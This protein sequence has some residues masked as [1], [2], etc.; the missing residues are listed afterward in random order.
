MIHRRERP[1]VP[2]LS[3]SSSLSPE[4][5][6]SRYRRTR[7][8]LRSGH[9]DAEAKYGELYSFAHAPR[10]IIFKHAASS[11]S[12]VFDMR[13]GRAQPPRSASGSK[14]SRTEVRSGGLPFGVCH[15]GGG[16][17]EDP[18][19]WATTFIGEERHHSGFK[20]ASG[21]FRGRGLVSRSSLAFCSSEGS[22]NHVSLP[23]KSNTPRSGE[24]LVC[25]VGWDRSGLRVNM[26]L[27][28]GGSRRHQFDGCLRGPA[29]HCDREALDVDWSDKKQHGGPRQGAGCGPV[30]WRHGQEGERHDGPLAHAA[31]A[32][33][34]GCGGRGPS[35]RA[36]VTGL[37]P[38]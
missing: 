27:R 30:C 7:L 31:G 34:A 20:L 35:S 21:H 36:R 4:G 28:F 22:G 32:A 24:R 2:P 16:A 23:A 11:I 19:R 17:Q 33:A 8:S 37:Q 29:L 9:E 3:P 6:P 26:C 1:I 38:R 5:W 15:R 25:R 13:P 12:T 10:A 18:D 14:K